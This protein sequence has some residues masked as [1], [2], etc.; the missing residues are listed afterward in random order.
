M[1]DPG[2]ISYEF[3]NSI[4]VLSFISLIQKKKKKSEIPESILIKVLSNYA[5]WAPHF[6]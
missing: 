6:L 4:S 5:G 1:L 3:V 2:L